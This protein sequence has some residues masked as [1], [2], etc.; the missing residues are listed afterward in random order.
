MFFCCRV[1][2]CCCSASEA[3]FEIPGPLGAQVPAHLEALRIPGTRKTSTVSRA[4][5]TG[6]R[7]T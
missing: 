6:N 5:A 2:E 1:L 4:S 7:V 3:E